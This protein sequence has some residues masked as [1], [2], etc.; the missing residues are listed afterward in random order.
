ME[1]SLSLTSDFSGHFTSEWS[2][3]REIWELLFAA[4][5]VWFEHTNFHVLDD[6]LI[7]TDC[8]D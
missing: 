2:S 3:I 4:M 5:I 6:K 7:E 1:F 8:A